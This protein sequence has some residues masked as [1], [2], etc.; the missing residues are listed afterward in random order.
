MGN[1]CTKTK[2]VEAADPVTSS[3]SPRRGRKKPG[4]AHTT[5][6]AAAP[7][8]AELHAIVDGAAGLVFF[9][10]GTLLDPR[11]AVFLAWQAATSAHGLHL[12]RLVFFSLE[13]V[14]EA[15]LVTRL[16]VEQV[17]SDVS[18]PAVLAAKDEAL[19]S[20]L[21]AFRPVDPVV[22]LL[23]YAKEK[24]R[25]VAVVGTVGRR[26]MVA[27]LNASGMDEEIFDAVVSCEDYTIGKP[28]PEGYTLAAERM[29]VDANRCVGFECNVDGLQA[30]RC[31]GMVAVDVVTF[32]GY[33]LPEKELLLDAG[34][35]A[36]V[37]PADVVEGILQAEPRE[38]VEMEEEGGYQH[39][40]SGR[41]EAEPVAA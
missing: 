10:E 14:P 7:T 17:R 41:T 32:E 21:C 19:P 23:R 8:T 28:D 26:D 15:D 16:C 36:P 38:Q 34:H 6:L 24:G 37:I 25:P 31:A 9:T 39:E 4:K 18:V 20:A 27:Q 1:A 3:Q 30:L 11:E 12:T 13:A 33:P 2:T 35:G 22:S 40:G 29:G 5:T